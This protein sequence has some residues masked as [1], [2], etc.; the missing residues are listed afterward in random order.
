MYCRNKYSVIMAIYYYRYDRSIELLH[1][2][3]SWYT[4]YRGTQTLSLPLP[5]SLSPL[6]I[7]EHVYFSIVQLHVVVLILIL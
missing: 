2:I 3:T 7:C 4:L 1:Y 6:S 5:P